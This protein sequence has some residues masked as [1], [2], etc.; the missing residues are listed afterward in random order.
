MVSTEETAMSLVC[1]FLNI[2]L[3]LPHLLWV[4]NS[5]IFMVFCNF[6]YS[7]FLLVA[8]FAV[9]SHGSLLMKN[10]SA[11]IFVSQQ[12]TFFF[13]LSRYNHRFCILMF[14]ILLSL[15]SHLNLHYLNIKKSNVTFACLYIYIYI[16]IYIFQL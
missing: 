5:S 16:Y 15:P 6:T 2:F 9:S 1:W 3:A 8:I 12:G 13:Q 11:Y 4:F 7:I 10:S 14:S